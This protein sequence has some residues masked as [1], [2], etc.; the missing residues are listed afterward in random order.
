VD[1]AE[2]GGLNATRPLRFK[3]R[4]RLDRPSEPHSTEKNLIRLAHILY[5]LILHEED[6]KILT[7]LKNLTSETKTV[8]DA[9]IT[10]KGT[11]HPELGSTIL[12]FASLKA[13]GN[14]AYKDYKDRTV[15]LIQGLEQEYGV[16]KN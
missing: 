11:L 7:D 15:K 4:R 10:T 16:S 3:T 5:D 2:C 14:Q 8:F 12:K 6:K 1:A 9:H 13:D